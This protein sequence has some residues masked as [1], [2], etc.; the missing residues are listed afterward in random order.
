M[1]VSDNSSPRLILVPTPV[2]NLGDITRRA[3]EALESADVV[4]CEDTRRTLKLLNHLG[5][6]KRLRS[7]YSYNQ[8]RRVGEV[9]SLLSRGKT[10]VYV[11]DSGTPGISD[12]GAAILRAAVEAGFPATVLPGP[13]AFVP[14]VV[15]STL[16]CDRFA[17][18]G[19]PPS[20][21][22]RRR[23]FLRGVAGLPLTLVFYEAPHR[24]TKFLADCVEI[25]GASRR[26]AVV[27]EISKLHEQL[28]RGSLEEV[29]RFFSE[30]PPRGEIVVVVEGASEGSA[31]GGKRD[32]ADEDAVEAKP[33]EPPPPEDR[34]ERCKRRHPD[35]G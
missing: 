8:A 23:R 2:G 3:V 29:L 13:T 18:L 10:V 26:C 12:P 15:A 32:R 4:F 5:I 22:K 6:K 25:L 27:R 21:P 14:A 34:D 16:R 30:K 31:N 11:S 28:V 33:P 19:F 7:L 1:L 24:L 9:L 20:T 35:D 17:F